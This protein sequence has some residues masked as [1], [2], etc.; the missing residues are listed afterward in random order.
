[1]S[2]G[3]GRRPQQF[4]LNSQQQQTEIAPKAPQKSLLP[5]AWCDICRVDC[6][7][8]EILEQHKNGKRHKR[9]VLRIQE[10]QAQQKLNS[11][12]LPSKTAAKPVLF[13]QGEVG[14]QLTNEVKNDVLEEST[15]GFVA[16]ENNQQQMGQ[17][18]PASDITNTGGFLT[19]ALQDET[20]PMDGLIKKRK[21]SG[22]DK[23][24]GSKQKMMRIGRGGKHF[25]SF[26]RTHNRPFERPKDRPRDRPRVCTVCNVMCDTMAVFECH[27]TGKKHISRI[28]RFEGHGSVYGPISVYIPPN[29]PTTYPNKGPEP[30]FYGLQTLETLQQGGHGV[31]PQQMES[32]AAQVEGFEEGEGVADEPVVKQNLGNFGEVGPATSGAAESM[33]GNFGEVGPATGGA[34]ESV[35]KQN[36]GNFGEVGPPT[37]AINEE[38]VVAMHDLDERSSLND[39]NVGET[40]NSAPCDDNTMNITI[41]PAVADVT[42]P[43]YE[44]SKESEIV[45]P[46]LNANSEDALPRGE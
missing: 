44:A 21:I 33:V 8:L 17:S 19:D 42:A 23:W 7:S 13:I 25:K 4:A 10:I 46:G 5:V 40:N 31:F 20:L 38:R 28:K 36:L 11:T 18:V 16:S 37:D 2:R 41:L 6:N 1:M 9:T 39:P 27:L 15:E 14:N 29:Q 24:S 3:R 43:E 30:L 26:D 45:V 12:E 34:A 32:V 35:V 22:Y